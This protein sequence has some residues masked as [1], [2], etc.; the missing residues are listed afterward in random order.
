MRLLGLLSVLT[1]VGLLFGGL[2]GAQLA[3]KEMFH[4]VFDR[5]E[6]SLVSVKVV[7]EGTAANS[8]FVYSQDGYIVTSNHVVVSDIG[9][10]QEIE[11]RFNQST[12][13]EEAEIVGRDDETDLAVLKVD[14]LPEGIDS[15]NVSDQ[16]PKEGEIVGILGNP[17]G[18]EGVLSTGQVIGLNESVTTKDGVELDN[19][20][21]ISV[22][23]APGNSGGP[24]LTPEG[25]VVGVV[26]ARAIEADIGFAVPAS[27]V[28]RIVPE[29]INQDQR[30]PATL[31]R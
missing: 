14:G 24:V 3:E 11:V 29:I 20:I 21:A 13:W 17:L 22:S 1:V 6:E 4:D 12:E 31:K 19:A 5:Y 16:A 23:V 30:V 18:F 8:G 26:S 7:D 25:E 2:A 9:A 15:L 28:N 27:A 10:E